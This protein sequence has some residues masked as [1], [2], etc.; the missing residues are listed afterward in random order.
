MIPSDSGTA[1]RP[2]VLVASPFEDEL[3]DRARSVAGDRAEIVHR[4]DLLP[5]MRYAADH[6]GVEGWVRSPG[7]QAEWDLSLIH[8]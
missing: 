3:V 6:D 4:P 5:P 1:A 7:Q 8:I 2:L